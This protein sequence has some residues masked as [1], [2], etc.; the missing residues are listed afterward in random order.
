MSKTPIPSNSGKPYHMMYVQQIEH[1][2][3]GDVDNLVNLIDTRLHTQEY[4]VI[5]HDKDAGEEPHVHCMFSFKNGRS[6]KNVAKQLGDKP[7]YI[8]KWNDKPNNGFAYLIHA[9][10]KAQSTGKHQ[11][12]PSEVKANFDYPARIVQIKAEIEA[13]RVEHSGSKKIRDLLNLLYIGAVTKT[14]V[15]QQLSGAQYAQHHRKIEEVWAKRLQNMAEAWREEKKAQNAEI[16]TIWIYGSAGTGKTSLAKE[17]VQKSGEEYYISGSSRDTFQGYS[18]EHKMILDELRPENI[19]Y[20]DLLRITDPHGIENGT[21]AP[22][23]YY[24]KAIACDL[25]IITSP[26]SPKEFYTKI[27]GYD[28]RNIDKFGQLE[29][30]IAL[31]VKMDQIYINKTEYDRNKGMYEEVPGTRRPNPYSAQNRPVTVKPTED[32]YGTLLGDTPPMPEAGEEKADRSG[33]G[34]Q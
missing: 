26:Y 1:L 30:R 2:P 17:Y 23:R 16:T 29:R 3:A 15:E 32:I 24:D 7:Q 34:P 25:I 9:T 4:A 18:G 14:E 12:D 10:A 20:Q 6:M 5:V 22:S 8:E 11:Y 31:T 19:P 21:M 27:F 33:E 28:I 13:A